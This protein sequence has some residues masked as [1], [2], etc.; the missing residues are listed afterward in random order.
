MGGGGS[1]RRPGI[2]PFF[3]FVALCSVEVMHVV[4]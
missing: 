3:D 2:E 1:K 4:L